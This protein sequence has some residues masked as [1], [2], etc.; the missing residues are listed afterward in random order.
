MINKLPYSCLSCRVNKENGISI[1]RAIFRS[2]NIYSIR[3]CNRIFLNDLLSASTVLKL[4][5]DK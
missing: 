3:Q 5:T 4:F 2:F 1:A